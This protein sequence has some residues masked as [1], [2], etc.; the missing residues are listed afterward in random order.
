[1]LVLGLSVFAAAAHAQAD[2]A[3]PAVAPEPLLGP[4][5]VPAPASE[6]GRG[7]TPLP[8]PEVARP[9]PPPEIN[10]PVTGYGFGG[11]QQPPGAPPNPPY[12]SRPFVT[13]H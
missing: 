8:Q 12:T 10:S 13:G 5:I 1:M 11:M 3:E 2:D 6:Y 9:L 4:I 7:V